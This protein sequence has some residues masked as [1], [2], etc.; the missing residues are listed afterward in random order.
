MNE[1]VAALWGD[2]AK[3]E[4]KWDFDI[5]PSP[6]FC[7]FA[8]QEKFLCK[9]FCVYDGGVSGFQLF[10]WASV[11]HLVVVR[12]SLVVTFRVPDCVVPATPTL[13]LTSV[14]RKRV[15]LLCSGARLHLIWPDS[16]RRWW[17]P[18]R[19]SPTSAQSRSSTAGELLVLF[20]NFH[21]GGMPAFWVQLTRKETVRISGE[22]ISAAI[23]GWHSLGLGSCAVH[24]PAL[25]TFTCDE[26][27]TC[28]NSLRV[29]LLK[30]YGKM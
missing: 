16:R 11:L 21:I 1:I 8:W 14:W 29:E 20:P 28:P 27:W 25:W 23:F 4:N 12:L 9:Y 5:E 2:V 6:Q 24:T 13:L 30:N 22:S 7:V 10:C 18:G 15:S 17:S 3:T 26:C 19:D